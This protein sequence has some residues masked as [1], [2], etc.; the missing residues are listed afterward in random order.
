MS[1]SNPFEP[2][3]SLDPRDTAKSPRGVSLLLREMVG[4]G[5]GC[6][7]MLLGFVVG[8]ILGPRL[9]LP[10]AGAQLGTSD[11]VECGMPV[12]AAMAFGGI[13]GSV[14]AGIVGLAV[15]AKIVARWP[16]RDG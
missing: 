11:D 14:L 7:F 3:R 12:M 5:T 13:L 10:S 16:T 1:E 15:V 8:A 2:P 6:L 9:F 4:C